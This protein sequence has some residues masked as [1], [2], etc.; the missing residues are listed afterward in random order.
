[1]SNKKAVEISTASS[2]LKDKQLITMFA[3]FDPLT[4][5]QNPVSPLK[6]NSDKATILLR[7]NLSI[8]S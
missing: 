4:T 6:S 1:M 7:T 8:V 5:N 2:F 3:G